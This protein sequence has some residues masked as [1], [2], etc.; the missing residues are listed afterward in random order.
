MMHGLKKFEDLKVT[1]QEYYDA[2]KRFGFSL[3]TDL[4]PCSQ[5]IRLAN[6]TERNRGAKLTV[7]DEVKSKVDALTALGRDYV[8][9]R[10]ELDGLW[11]CCWFC[12]KQYRSLSFLQPGATFEFHCT[13]LHA[14]PEIWQW[15]ICVQEEATR[16][17]QLPLCN[18][19]WHDESNSWTKQRSQSGR[20]P[21]S[22]NNVNV[23]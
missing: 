6:A 13:I 1:L 17:H 20:D 10:Q 9:E 21:P 12:T 19:K 4:T 14:P 15:R 11:E 5:N 18:M 16:R 2:C 7:E 22:C 23:L 3:F 8:G